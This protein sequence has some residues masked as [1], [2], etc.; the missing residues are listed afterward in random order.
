M[1]R[2]SRRLDPEEETSQAAAMER[3]TLNVRR[4]MGEGRLRDQVRLSNREWA[5]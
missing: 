1:R 5:E 3:K 4:H 2:S